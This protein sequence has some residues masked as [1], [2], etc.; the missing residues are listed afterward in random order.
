VDAADGWRRR[1]DGLLTAQRTGTMGRSGDVGDSA[2]GLSNIALCGGCRPRGE[3]EWNGPQ[4]LL[5]KL[6]GGVVL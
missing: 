3:I 2:S 1:E 4:L 5:V 6:I